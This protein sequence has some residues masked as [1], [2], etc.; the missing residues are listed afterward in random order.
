MLESLINNA[1]GLHSCNF[2]KETPTQV[3]SCEY[4]EIFKNSFYYRAPLVTASVLWTITML[5]CNLVL[6]NLRT[7]NNLNITNI[8]S[9]GML[10]GKRQLL[11]LSQSRFKQLLSA[12]LTDLNINSTYANLF[13]HFLFPRFLLI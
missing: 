2:I 4:C 3:F 6:G 5:N 7:M 1:A 13:Q 10:Y 9:D 8:F 11:L 12:S